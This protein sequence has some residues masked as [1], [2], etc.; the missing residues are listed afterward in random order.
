MEPLPDPIADV[1]LPA[2]DEVEALPEVLGAMPPGYR[3]IVVDNDS[4]DATPVVAVEMGAMVVREP[5]RGFGAACYAGL[6]AAGADIVCFMD[7]DASFD[8]TQLPRVVDPVRAGE[9][10]L[11][12]GA[13]RA[14]RGAWPAHLR[15]ANRLLAAELKR[16]SGVALSDLGPMRATRRESLIGLGL[17]DR[18][19]GWPL[20][21]I[22]RAAAEGWRITEVRVDYRPRVGRSKVTGTVM[23]TARTVSDMA[24]L[25]AD[26]GR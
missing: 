9:A 21:M 7:A 17:T 1:I 24:R 20:E 3:P 23:G 16:R 10:D 12:L 26:T 22:L 14:V 11:V 5:Q 6:S 15:A 13:R 2:L 8:A 18:R 25:L 4:R 19:S